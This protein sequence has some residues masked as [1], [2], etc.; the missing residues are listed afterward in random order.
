[1]TQLS[2]SLLGP[3]QAW[4]ADGILRPLRT[5]KERALLAYLVVENG[6]NHRRE[7]LADL[8]WPDRIYRY[9]RGCAGRFKR[10]C[11]AGSGCI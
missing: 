10:S 5:A 7:K 11:L 9:N 4:T 2:L 6:Q 1:M 8:F 3:F